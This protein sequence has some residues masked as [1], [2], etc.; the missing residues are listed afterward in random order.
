MRRGTLGD[1]TVSGD[2]AVTGQGTGVVSV[3]QAH[4]G[5]EQ[6]LF[7]GG[8]GHTGVCDGG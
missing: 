1:I 7:S 3:R 2:G 8:V 5:L 4:G 6:G